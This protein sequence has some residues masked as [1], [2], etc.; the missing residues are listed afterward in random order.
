MLEIFL[1]LFFSYL[2]R[3]LSYIHY[4][5][6]QMHSIKWDKTQTIQCH[7]M[8]CSSCYMFWHPVP[9]S[10]ILLEQSST[11]P[12]C[13]LR[14]DRSH[15]HHQNIN[16]IVEYTRFT[17]RNPQW[18][19]AKIMCYWASTSTGLQPLIFCLEHVYKCMLSVCDPKG[20]CP[21]SVCM[22]VWSISCWVM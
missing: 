11:S 2:Y 22:C 13:Q 17:N 16:K 12:A 1:Q 4:I 14:Y 18:C 15:C 21:D 6:Q 5:N 9:S 10:G 20:F 3:V 7:F 8:M 19:D